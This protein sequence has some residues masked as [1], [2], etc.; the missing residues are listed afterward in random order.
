MTN[1]LGMILE[2]SHGNAKYF[3]VNKHVKDVD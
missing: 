2:V 3:Q 1:I